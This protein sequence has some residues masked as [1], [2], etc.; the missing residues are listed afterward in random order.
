MDKEVTPP[1]TIYVPKVFFEDGTL[2]SGTTTSPRF[3]GDVKYICAVAVS[4]VKEAVAGKIKYVKSLKVES[5]YHCGLLE[6]LEEAHRLLEE[7]ETK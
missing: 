3:P 7:L 2:P 5:D 6:A 4:E 1:Q